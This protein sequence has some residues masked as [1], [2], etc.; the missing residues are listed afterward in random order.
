MVAWASRLFVR[1]RSCFHGL[2]LGKKWKWL[3]HTHTET[4]G[5]VER[6][7]FGGTLWSQNSLLLHNEQDLSIAIPYRPKQ[8]H[9]TF[10]R[11]VI[12][13]ITLV[14]WVDHLFQ[15]FFIVGC[16]DCL[17]C[18]VTGPNQ[19]FVT[20][21]GDTL[22]SRFT[23]TGFLIH[24]QLPHCVGFVEVHHRGSLDLVRAPLVFCSISGVFSGRT[25]IGRF[26]WAL[27]DPVQNHPPCMEPHGIPVVHTCLSFV[28]TGLS[29]LY[30]MWMMN[31]IGR[32]WSL[33]ND[34]SVILSML[35]CPDQLRPSFRPWVAVARQ[36]SSSEMDDLHSL[37]SAAFFGLEFTSWSAWM[38]GLDFPV[39][40]ISL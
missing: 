22:S 34:R 39:R 30:C 5:R 2:S 3:G 8:V 6:V 20:G 38:S 11:G 9:S 19:S 16:M 36:P 13:S 33:M 26:S 35:V 29:W 40:G 32:R 7:V 15:P 25:G 27:Q 10:S 17:F 14:F 1:S 23:V 21:T 24:S 18:R 37:S 4:T 28:G 31:G 12:R